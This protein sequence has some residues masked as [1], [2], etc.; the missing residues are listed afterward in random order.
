MALFIVLEIGFSAWIGRKSY[1]VADTATN[2][3]YTALNA[4][5]DLVFRGVTLY[6][7]MLAYSMTPIR[8]EV[9]WVYWVALF[10]LQDLAYYALHC[11]DH[12]VRI[13]W[14]AH[15]THHSS[16]LFNL[17]VAIRSSV[18][19]PLY[20]FLF[21]LPLGF[22]G[23]EPLHILFMYAVCQ[24]YGFW[25][26]TE[27][28]GRLGALEWV[29]V[30]PR[31]HSV[32]HA[33]NPQYLD[34][35]MGMVLIVWDR[36]FGTFQD[37][38]EGVAPNYGTTTKPLTTN[39]IGQIFDE[40][41]KLAADMKRAPDLGTKLRYM[42]MPPGWSHDGQSKTST[43]LRADMAVTQLGLATRSSIEVASVGAK[44]EVSEVEH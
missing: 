24:S 18:F 13:F 43:Q 36:L 42:Y 34:K 35:N 3:T 29:L 20:R 25:V 39:P 26:H 41:R 40:W 30:T 32:H 22:M 15:V 31:L 2:L 33:S 12:Y 4:S 27:Y 5:I 44:R 10:L 7:L 1:T 23:F 14:A 11:A 6:M 8:L 21:Y 37:Q 38:I 19:Q 16:Q 9:N 28:I 17:T